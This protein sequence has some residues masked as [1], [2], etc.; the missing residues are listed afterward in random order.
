MRCEL[1][2]IFTWPQGRTHLRLLQHH[3]HNLYA[4][5]LLPPIIVHLNVFDRSAKIRLKML[6]IFANFAQ[7]FASSAQPQMVGGSPT[8]P[9]LRISRLALKHLLVLNLPLGRVV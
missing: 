7:I 1:T 2:L 9:G 4:A 5:E 6:Y 3:E 8:S